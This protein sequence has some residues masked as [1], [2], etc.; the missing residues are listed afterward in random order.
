ML[1]DV[2]KLGIPLVFSTFLCNFATCLKELNYD[3]RQ[4]YSKDLHYKF[5]WH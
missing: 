2:K 1:N 5:R 4:T 3:N